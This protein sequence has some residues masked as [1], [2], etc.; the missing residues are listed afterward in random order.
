MSTLAKGEC[1]C[2]I[3]NAESALVSI[4]CSGT[5]PDSQSSV[6]SPVHL[7]DHIGGYRAAHATFAA[8]ESRYGLLFPRHCLNK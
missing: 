1:V 6:P 7:P 3:N 2:S 5:T 8:V 4:P